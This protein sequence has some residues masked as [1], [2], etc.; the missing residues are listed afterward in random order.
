M[1][2]KSGIAYNWLIK[3]AVNAGVLPRFTTWTMR[4]LL[5]PLWWIDQTIAPW[6]DKVWADDRETAGYFVTARKP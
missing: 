4:A 3:N 5:I 2:F 1:Y 6:L